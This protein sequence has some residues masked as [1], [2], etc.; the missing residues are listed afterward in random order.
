MALQDVSAYL[1][2]PSQENLDV[3]GAGDQ[4]L[5]IEKFDGRVHTTVQKDSIT[6]GV[7]RWTPLVGTD[8]MSNNV[9]GNP[10][11]EKVIPGVEP[12]G[13]TIE[14][15]KMIVQ[16]TQPIIAKIIT[17]MLA[18]IQDHLNIKSRTPENFGKKIAKHEDITL[19]LQCIKSALYEHTTIEPPPTSISGKGSGGILAQGTVLTL[20]SA[21]D[22]V[23]PDKLD[24]AIMLMHQKLAELDLDPMADGFLYMRPE[25][26]FTLLKHEKLINSRYSATN[27]D[28]SESMV[29]KA[30]GIPIKMTNRIMNT[31]DTVA[32]PR[33]VDSI[34]ALYGSA[35]ETSATEA[36]CKC[37]YATGETIMVAT[38]IPLTTES[39]WDPKTL[40]W[41]LQS[42]ECFGAAPDRTDMVGAIFAA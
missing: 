2:W 11:L 36:K 9:M 22:E 19:L 7:W 20:G 37:I 14:V 10:T 30:S 24:A 23:D 8:T 17:P 32:S 27:G 13:G 15:G 38:S 16:V 3:S 25:Q 33:A 26:Y 6:S 40:S 28:Y 1:N 4:A 39:F 31:T 29:S 12:P 18:Q 35:Y 34:A 41:Y 5:L 21:L 42:Y